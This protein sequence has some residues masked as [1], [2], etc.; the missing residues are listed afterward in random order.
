MN[1]ASSAAAAAGLCRLSRRQSH[2]TATAALVNMIAVTT[3][4][5]AQLMP[6]TECARKSAAAMSATGHAASSMR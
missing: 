4:T 2:S 5:N 6:T 1:A 3:G